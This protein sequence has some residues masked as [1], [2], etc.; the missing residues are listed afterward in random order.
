MRKIAIALLS[1]GLLACASK[2]ESEKSAKNVKES[3]ENIISANARTGEFAKE[4]DPFTIDTAYIKGN[5]LFV[6]VTFGGGCKDH[7]FELI[8]SPMIAK[9]YPAQRAIQLVHSANGDNCKALVKKTVQVDVSTL[10]D[11]QKEGHVIHY[12]LDGY[13]PRLEHTYVKAEKAKP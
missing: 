1:I 7:N 9:S 10:T 13:K 5:Q 6:D 11:N 4:N 3:K 12:N 8:G 2:K